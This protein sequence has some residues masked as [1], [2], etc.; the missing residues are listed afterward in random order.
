MADQQAG[1]WPAAG[2]KG[3]VGAAQWC[4]KFRP[5]ER[6]TVA[7]VLPK[8]AC[9]AT[10]HGWCRSRRERGASPG[11]LRT[12][13]PAT[14]VTSPHRGVPGRRARGRRRIIPCDGGLAR[15]SHHPPRPGPA[16]R[17]SAAVLRARLVR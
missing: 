9:A 2:V 13:G 15:D 14:E 3:L 7:D 6:A 4:C 17:P 5:A 1:A 16:A 10:N 11:A 8:L 12:S